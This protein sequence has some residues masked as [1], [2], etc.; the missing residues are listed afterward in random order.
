MKMIKLSV[1]YKRRELLSKKE[2][3]SGESHSPMQQYCCRTVVPPLL[4][5]SA[6][7]AGEKSCTQPFVPGKKCF[8]G[9][10]EKSLC[11][12]RKPPPYPT[13]HFFL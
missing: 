2:R 13:Y 5:I 11:K 7:G 4:I 3:E 12:L 8:T 6:A 10:G 9:N 1:W